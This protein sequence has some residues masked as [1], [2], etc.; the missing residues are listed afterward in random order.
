M[1]TKETVS[2]LELSQEIKD[3]INALID[4]VENQKLSFKELIEI[5]NAASKDN[6][7]LRVEIENLRQ[8]VIKNNNANQSHADLVIK[9]NTLARRVG[10]P[11]I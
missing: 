3:Q 7:R 4:T 1:L 9:Y 5:N 8:E 11:T 6:D 10:T 2:G